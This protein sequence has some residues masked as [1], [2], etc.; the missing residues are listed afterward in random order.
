[1]RLRFLG[2]GSAFVTEP[3]NFHS[4]M[5]LEAD[6]PDGVQRLLI[7]CGS[8]CRWAM[9]AQGLSQRDVD[10]VYI[11]HLHSDHIGGMEWLGFTTYFNP[12]LGRPTLFIPES[13]AAP[14]WHTCLKGGMEVLDF[15]LATLDSFFDVRKVPDAGSFHWQ[16][17]TCHL[18][19]TEHL[20][21]RDGASMTSYGLLIK[22]PERTAYLTT[23]TR[24]N[25]DPLLETY[26]QADVIF[27]DCETA[28]CP[29]GAHSHYSHLMGVPEELR[30]R[31]WLYHY[32]AGPK[33][34]CVQDGFLG[35]VTP[36][37]SFDL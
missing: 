17:A 35:Y 22:G 26:P 21:A 36:G 6:T 18:I 29:S 28:A 33:P 7:D 13:L 32:Q 2:T 20:R 10:A 37:Q 8:D 24:F 31:M 19:P 9:A 25:A 14:L 12:D 4:N 5:L 34:D 30:G 16:G 1:M 23:D 11:S 27:Q 3:G 15:G